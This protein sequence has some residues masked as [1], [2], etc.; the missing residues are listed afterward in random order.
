[1]KEFPL[2]NAALA[3]LVVMVLSIGA[4]LLVPAAATAGKPDL[5]MAIFSPEHV[6]AYRPV[7][8][9]FEKEN[10]C[11]VQ[12]QLVDQK[13]LQDRL[14]SSLQVGADV[15]DIVEL[16]GGTLGIF[17]QARVEDVKLLDLTDRVESD[18]LK[19]RVVESRF[20]RWTSRGRIFALPHDVHPVML[21]YRRDLCERL[22]IDVAKLTTWDKFVAVGRTLKDHHLPDDVVGR[23]YMIDLPYD[24]SELLKLLL[25]QR[26]GLLFD[27]NGRVTFD[28]E[29]AVDLLCWY[30]RQTRGDNLVGYS[31]GGGQSFSKSL[32]DGLCLFYVCPDWRTRQFES[33]APSVAGKIALMPMPAWEEG[34]RRTST[35]G[36]S[37]LAITR[38]CKKPDLAWKLA[39]ALYYDPASVAARFPETNILPPVKAAWAYPPFDRSSGYFSGQAIGRS[40]ADL[41]ADVPRDYDSAFT[42]QASN[43]LVEAFANIAIYYSANGEVGLHDFAAGELH[44]CADQVRRLMGRNAFLTTASAEAAR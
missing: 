29:A 22:G 20:G 24:G 37:G 13:A 28:S 3:M 43:K 19:E 34:G 6:A 14:Q 9:R 25:L 1:M 2:G 32:I 16:L 41:A 31:A 35:W 21:A 8:E 12:L 23:H 39:M 17:T 26:G 7:V 40:F 36:G 30:A 38:R 15:P 11:R 4:T 42:S 33:D 44:R 5:V 27:S 10:G 18:R